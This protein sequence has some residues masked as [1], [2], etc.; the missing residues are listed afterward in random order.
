MQVLRDSEEQI[1]TVPRIVLHVGI[2][3][4]LHQ[5]YPWPLEI[6]REVQRETTAQP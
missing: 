2:T 6:I 5:G 3:T 1:F 4:A